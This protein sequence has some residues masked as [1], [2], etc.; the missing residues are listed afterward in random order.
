MK[1]RACLCPE[2]RESRARWTAL[3][4]VLAWMV[5]LA[6]PGWVMGQETVQTQSEGV[7]TVSRGSSAILT[8]PDDIVRVSVADPEIAEPVVIP[9]NEV[10]INAKEIGSTSLIVWGRAGTGR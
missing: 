1:E 5:G 8:R 10:L 4:I 3:R 7:I 2:G 9:P 6:V